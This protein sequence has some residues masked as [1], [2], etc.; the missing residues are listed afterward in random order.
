MGRDAVFPDKVPGLVW[1]REARHQGL[2]RKKHTKALNSSVR[3]RSALFDEH[4]SLYGET[5]VLLRARTKGGRDSAVKTRD[6]ID[7]DGVGRYEHSRVAAE[8]YEHGVEAV[9]WL[10]RLG[11]LA[12]IAQITLS[13]QRAEQYAQGW[14]DIHVELPD[15]LSARDGTNT[16][17]VCAQHDTSLGSAHGSWTRK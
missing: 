16:R 13:V 14:M 8:K 6:N 11:S 3:R 4:R 1:K 5:S 2:E 17:V 15:V 10:D 9:D 7:V 12:R